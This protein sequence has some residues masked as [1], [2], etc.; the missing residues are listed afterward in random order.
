MV[1]GADPKESF[2][3]PGNDFVVAGDSADT[4]FGN[5]GR[6][7]I[8]GGGQADLLQ[9]NNGDPF[10]EGPIGHDVIDGGGGN[11]DYD[12]EGGDDIMLGGTGT[13]RFEGMIGFD[14]VTNKGAAQ[15]ADWDLNF[16]GL[17]PPDIDNIR[18]RFDNVEG[19][20]GHNGD[21]VLRG[22]SFT[23]V[24]LA[25][26]H[27][28]VNVDLIKGLSGL[29]GG[30]QPFAAGNIII[31]GAGSDVIEGR[32]G[33]DLIDGDRWLNARISVTDPNN[34][35]QEI[36]SVD[37]MREVQSDVFADRIQPD[38]LQVVREIITPASTP[39]EIDTAEFSD[40]RENYQISVGPGGS[41]V[42]VD[43][44]AGAQTDGTDTVKN[45]ERLRFSDRTIDVTSLPDHPASGQP[46]ISDTTPDQ[47][48]LLTVD[49]STI[50]DP[51]GTTGA[52]FRYQWQESRVATPGFRGHRGRHRPELQAR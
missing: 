32:G 15:A 45:V 6:D 20:S 4:V 19:L 3:G 51:D 33:D 30:E 2:A 9:G 16:T 13:E 48:Q 17:L 22:D 41:Q 35:E 39:G 28:L 26:D 25:N 49:T 44:V 8:E 21:D 34:P 27:E 12:S 31:G 36:R 38:Q 11:D 18:D 42:T 7:W 46:L 40:L 50:V 1:G 23:A 29:L 43:H 10:Q 37:S 5:E 14:W 52:T 47:G 24:E